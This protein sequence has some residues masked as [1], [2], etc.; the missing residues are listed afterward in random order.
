VLAPVAALGPA[1]PLDRFTGQFEA[2]R[3]RPQPE[4]G[5]RLLDD[6]SS[7]KGIYGNR[8]AR[9]LLVALMARLAATLGAIVGGVLVAWLL[10]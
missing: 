7:L 6:I 4:D 9:V 1:L 3:R 5:Q 8:A 2:R 10:I